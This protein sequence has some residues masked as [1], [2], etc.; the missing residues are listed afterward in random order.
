MIAGSLV[1]VGVA[2]APSLAQTHGQSHGEGG[3]GGEGTAGAGAAGPTA[4]LVALG[5]VE[6]HIRAGAALYAMGEQAMAAS[7]MK[8]PGDEIYADL[9]PMLEAAGAEG[10]AVELE[11]LAA[12]VESGAEQ[13]AV[14]DA[15]AA[16]VRRIESA[17]GASG[18][19]PYE[20]ARA[21]EALVRT[22]AEEYAI[23]I[24]D[25]QVANLHEYQDAWGFVQVAKEQ[26]ARLA[27]A[28][29]E[30]AAALGEALAATDALF[31]GLAPQGTVDGDAGILLGAAA[32]IELAGLQLR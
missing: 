28:D 1:A 20:R 4:L 8:H 15:E 26:A 7:H 24:V 21:I 30:V 12:A 32:R 18:A 29:P 11:A 5:L 2:A 10:F 17:R 19:S 3:E 23:G 25:G 6:G 9:V 31:P 13:P 14:T 16:V 22:A 27:D